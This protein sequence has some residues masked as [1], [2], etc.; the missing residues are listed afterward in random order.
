MT[1]DLAAFVRARL[2]EDER[3]ARAAEP[4]SWY[5]DEEGNVR[6]DAEYV[7]TGMLGAIEEAYRVHIVRHD[8][9]RVLREVEAK[10]EIVRR[11]AVWVNEP[12]QHPNGLVSPRAVLARQNLRDL[13]AVWSGHPDYRQE[14]KP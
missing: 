5:C 13:A 2:D 8:P 4:C 9:A 10:R 1:D 14:W 7:A 6:A 11:C 3:Y 12:D